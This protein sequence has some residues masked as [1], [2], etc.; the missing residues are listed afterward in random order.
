M[1]KKILVIL[2]DIQR[3]Q[4]HEWFVRFINPTLFEIEYALINSKGSVMDRFLLDSGIETWHFNYKS[5][6]DL[7]KL[8]LSLYKRMKIGKYD[9]I[10]THL[11]ESSLAG[12]TAGYF[13]RVRKRIMT[14]H[15]SDYHHVWFP[16]A[17]KYDR[18]MNFLATD[19][20]AISNNVMNVFVELENVCTDK[21]HLIHHGLDMKE[22]QPGAVNSERI[23]NIKNKYNLIGKEVVV[24]A[25]SRFT[26]LKGLQYL[27]PAFIKL[28]CDFPNA[29]LVLANA[30]GDYSN[31][32]NRMLLEI[33]NENKRIIDFENDIAA[34]YKAFSCFVHIP[35]NLTAEAFGQTYIESLASKIPSIFTLSGVAPEFA[36]DRKNCFIVPYCDPEAVYRS[37]HYILTN[38]TVLDSIKEEGYRIVK[39]QFDIMVKIHKLERLYLKS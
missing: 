7:P 35:I 38:A 23:A 6:K 34:L 9:I 5:K 24:G 32:V 12:L 2:N 33:P 18:I 11:F 17:V 1:R 22:Y 31:Q 14:R 26:E 4:E 29:V 13:A 36:V 27:I 16:S 39:D 19:L 37:L 15:Y 20:I 25:I 28:L 10:H 30:T 21:I 3:A 8:F